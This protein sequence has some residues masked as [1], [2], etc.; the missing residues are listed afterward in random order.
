MKQNYQKSETSEQQNSIILTVLVHLK[1]RNE[2]M[3]QDKNE[4]QC[5]GEHFG[6]L[7]RFQFGFQ[8]LNGTLSYGELS[9]ASLIQG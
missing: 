7:K 9:T 3:K 4:K 6:D 1:A 8:F 2:L 5:T